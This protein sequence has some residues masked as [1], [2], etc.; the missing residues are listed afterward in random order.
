MRF[1][2]IAALGML[3]M[4]MV[5]QA[6]SHREAPSIAMD[7]AADITDIY[8]F[9]SPNDPAKWVFVLNVSPAG[10][11]YAA[12][13]WYRFDDEVLYEMHIDR[14]GDG[15]EDVTYQFRFKTSDYRANKGLII[16]YFPNISFDSAN[17]KYTGLLGDGS[18][19]QS[20]SVGRVNDG[21][22][23]AAATEVATGIL[24]APPRVGPYTT[25]GGPA[26][27]GSAKVTTAYQAYASLAGNSVKDVGNAKFFAGSRNDPFFVD[28]GGIF[29]RV[30]VR[31]PSVTGTPVD[32]LLGANVMS[33]VMELP[34]ADFLQAGET[35]FGYWATTSRPQASILRPA[36]KANKTGG[37]WVQVSRLGNP[38]VNE[39]VI[40]V[41]DK[42]KFNNTEP[43]D[44]AANFAG[45]VLEPQLAFVLNT[46]YGTSNALSTVPGFIT[47]I[48]LKDRWD[49]VTA[50]VTG[51]PG[52]NRHPN[53]PTATNYATT[54]GDM[55][56]VNTAF[57]IQEWPLS[58]RNLKDDTV[59]S[60]LSFLAQCKKLS[61]LKTVT[62]SSPADYPD[63]PFGKVDH[64][65]APD[66]SNVPSL[67]PA[68]C[69]LDDFV[70]AD[71][72]TTGAPADGADASVGF[73][74]GVDFPYLDVPY[75][76]YG[77]DG[78]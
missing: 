27:K 67:I 74:P 75:G 48:D 45:Q 31:I 30:A 72:K 78:L 51:L 7:P 19:H 34:L 70:S 46:L 4:P 16:S 64:P 55:I 60:A 49:M 61:G 57:G 42:D 63:N 47:D 23:S 54:G 73:R 66:V 58:G 22:R 59:K 36:G 5:A 9:K 13:N 53:L 18:L 37:G 8:T 62:I 29:D 76:A 12:P 28:L 10:L 68:N 2:K 35:F 77:T 26:N 38:L 33:I 56:R 17:N 69:L 14:T 3:T 15:I 50:F 71:T 44:D 20:Y 25:D 32:S 24:V 6:S 41:E 52:I 39:I 43:K 21:R 11:G 40:K 1:L 65:V